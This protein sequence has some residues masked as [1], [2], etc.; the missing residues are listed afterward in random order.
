M[1]HKFVPKRS[2]RHGGPEKMCSRQQGAI[3]AGKGHLI[4]PSLFRAMLSCGVSLIA[5]A[6]IY[7]PVRA[8]NATPIPDVSVNAPAVQKNDGSATAGY[9]VDNTGNGTGPFWGD[10]PLQDAPY[11]VFV[12]SS[13]MINN[14]QAYNVQDALRYSP[15]VTFTNPG[16]YAITGAQIRGFSV[17]ATTSF[18]GVPNAYTVDGLIGQ[19]GTTFGDQY[20]ED[21]ERIQV[22][23][24]VNGFLFGVSNVAGN[25]NADLKRPTALPLFVVDTGTNTGHNGYIHGD[26]GGPLI[27]PG[28]DPGIFGYRINLVGQDGGTYV[29]NQTIRRYLLSGAFDIHLP[30]NLLIQLNASRS[31]F[32]Q[33]GSTPL[34]Y[35]TV[36]T[37]L[38]ND[39][40]ALQALPFEHSPYNTV[41]MVG[42]GTKWEPNDI[43]TFR[44]R[45]QY[46][47]QKSIGAG[48][49]S[50]ISES[51]TLTG[52]GT[53]RVGGSASNAGNYTHSGYAFLDTN[54]SI[55]DVKNKV[56]TGFSGYI[57]EAVTGASTMAGTA[58]GT[59][60]T[61]CNIFTVQT[62]Y[63]PGYLTYG[64]QRS[65]FSGL[66]SDQNFMIGDE[67]KAFDDRLI[68]LG[69]GNYA[70]TN[71]I[72]YAATG[73]RSGAYKAAALTPTA[74]ATYKLQPW[75]SVYAS[76]QQSLTPGQVVGQFNGSGLTYTN[77]GAI[78]PPY[79]GTQWETGLKATV[80]TNMLMTLAFF[81]IDQQNV[82]DQINSNGTATLTVGGAEE[83]KGGEFTVIG[84][85]WEDLTLVGGLT[86]M[87]ARI[88][89]NPS[90][91]YQNGALAANVSPETAKFYAEYTIP[92]FAEAPWMHGLT[93]T[94]GI[95]YRS[96]FAASLPSNYGAAV[97]K[98]PGY[99]VGDLGF[100]YAS[101]LYDHPI[102]YRLS[103]TNVTNYAYLP[104]IGY[105]GQGR[106]FLAS[107]EF[108][109]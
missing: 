21:K 38:P 91:P 72:S 7:Q 5:I 74:L 1:K 67:I 33:W 31:A 15:S 73:G 11:S 44:D 50:L 3:D 32:E 52:A 75:L 100:R 29:N 109:W 37:R 56:T 8:Q 61:T 102:I 53:D 84:K 35:P 49:Y 92:L 20:V 16:N 4:V 62:C 86:V 97:T 85:L 99:A 63:T 28:L 78:V 25:I 87:D 93:L 24:G 77:F 76:F 18:G 103:V 2:T 45:W 51:N 13:D 95:S 66:V 105:L 27:I 30:T 89:T 96:S 43:F 22:L 70:N 104:S 88:K 36:G 90:S 98:Y 83:H 81:K 9:R 108:K 42:L 46:R 6:S 12:T 48:G 19:G 79:I 69:G 40:D 107:T 106:T 55:F 47:E 58:I 41:T 39:P 101:T 94:G 82:F 23:D 10:L 64:V 65:Y 34:L 54:F 68:I 17:N 71:S 60:P 26:F 14:L 57:N 80:G 59:N